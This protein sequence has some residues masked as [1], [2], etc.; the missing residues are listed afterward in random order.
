MAV[1]AAAVVRPL[2]VLMPAQEAE[3]K[4]D[5]VRSH[6]VPHV[7]AVQTFVA[8]RPCTSVLQ[9]AVPPQLQADG[10]V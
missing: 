10:V 8:H 7:I 1:R 4:V 2:P 6:S 3:E 9:H 5:G